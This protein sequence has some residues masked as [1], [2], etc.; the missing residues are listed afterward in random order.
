MGI[1]SYHPLFSS[2]KKR[3][4]YGIMRSMS[5]PETEPDELEPTQATA[6]T[7]NQTK[8]ENSES[9]PG[10]WRRLRWFLLFFVFA[11]L[12]AGVSGYYTGVRQRQQ[13]RQS[14]VQAQAEEQFRRGVEDL[15]AGRY[16]LARQRFE[17]V[18]N[19]DPGY[20]GAPERLAEALLHLNRPTSAP[21]P[22]ATAT[23]NLAPVEELFE[24]AEQALRDEQWSRAIETLL[25]LRAK[26]MGYRA[27]RVDGM[28]Y[29]AL[30]N[31]GVQR[32]AEEGMLEEG[33]YDLARAQTFGPLDRDAVNWKD[34]AALYLE[35]NSF[36]GVNWAQAVSNFA[37]VY[38]VA[39]YL[40]NDAYIKY[41]VSAQNYADQLVEAGDP[42]AAEGYYDESILAWENATVYPTATEARNMCRTATAPAPRPQPDEP[43][44]TPDGEAT[45]TPT[46]TATNTPD[47]EG[48]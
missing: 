21:T 3:L 31:R 15:E 47:G 45:P 6:S 29:L 8:P 26:D 41:A 14:A 18:I 7:T 25:A 13:A 23:P 1:A 46:P 5:S 34:W 33:M 32:I 17:Y 11:A 2:V 39:P 12:V 42:C 27:V 30:R 37:Q 4:P 40:R 35:A 36:M 38:L 24:Q 44:A 43:T 20:P 48:G 28:M 19:L 22:Q 9:R 16:E 10:L